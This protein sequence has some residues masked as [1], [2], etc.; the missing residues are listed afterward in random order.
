MKL[1]QKILLAASASII[2]SGCFQSKQDF[3]LRGTEIFENTS[4]GEVKL[5]TNVSGVNA[6]QRGPDG[7]TIHFKTDKEELPRCAFLISRPEAASPDYPDPPPQKAPWNYEKIGWAYTI[8]G[9]RKYT[10]NAGGYLGNSGYFVYIE[11]SAQGNATAIVKNTETNMTKRI[12]VDKMLFAQIIGGEA[13]FD[14][15]GFAGENS[16]TYYYPAQYAVAEGKIV[17]AIERLLIAV[18]PQNEK[19]LGSVLLTEPTYNIIATSFWFFSK[20]ESPLAI[21]ESGW[22]GGREFQALLDVS[23]ESLKVQPLNVYKQPALM[24]FKT[25]FFEWDGASLIFHFY[26]EK[27]ITK[28]VKKEDFEFFTKEEN[29]TEEGYTKME[30]KNGEIQDALQATGK[31]TEVLCMLPPGMFSSSCL[32]LTKPENYRADPGKPLA[33]L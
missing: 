2:L 11:L 27:D 1:F 5:F 12:P 31:Y 20:P 13:S 19:F 33:K 4:S 24:G 3:V 17:F 30:K 21:I 16:T 18:D 22:E 28:E 26:Q 15:M 14:L 25:Q 7:K 8:E 32:A 6:V 9:C 10:G 29:M 23:G